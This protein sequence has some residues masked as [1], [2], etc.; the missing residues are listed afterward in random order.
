MFNARLDA[1]KLLY[2]V[3]VVLYLMPWDPSSSYEGAKLFVLLW[4]FVMCALKH[5]EIRS[6]AG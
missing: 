4:K 6:R 3:H 5:C 2:T 1:M